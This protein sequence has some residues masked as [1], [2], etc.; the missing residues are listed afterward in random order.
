MLVVVSTRQLAYGSNNATRCDR[1]L[2]APLT[3][4]S[5]PVSGAPPAPAPATL[6]DLADLAILD[7]LT[8][9]FDSKFYRVKSGTKR[10]VAAHIDRGRA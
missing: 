4:P 10:G 9:H 2:S 3:A 6:P 5:V 7:Y 1:V 8:N